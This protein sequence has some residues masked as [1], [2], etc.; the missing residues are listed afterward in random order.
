MI[1][2]E[3]A[4]CRAGQKILL[5][6]E[7]LHIQSG[8]HV[9]VLGKN[10]AGKSTLLKLLTGFI[11]PQAGRVL[12]NN[13]PVYPHPGER[14]LRQVRSQTGQVFQGLHLVGRL[15]VLENVLIGGLAAMPR[16]RSWARLFT[17][18][19]TQKA[20]DALHTVG[21]AGFSGVRADKL[22]GGERQKVAVARMLMQQPSLILA[23]EPTAA[24]DPTAA[25]DTC[26]LLRRVSH[27]RTLI[28]V[29]HNEALVPM[30]ADRVI[31]LKAGKIVLDCPVDDQLEQRLSAL[32]D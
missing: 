29:L 20:M 9:A 8:E 30:L 19:E 10:G 6:V 5:D 23:D 26:E 11:S 3:N 12:V 16:L 32:Y 7:S 2:I 4:V 25:R 27:Q 1:H 18:I 31:G 22:S 28:S 24:L 13:Q 17:P 14:K 15:T 21:M